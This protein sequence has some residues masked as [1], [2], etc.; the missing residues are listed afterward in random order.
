[1]LL[2]PA[3]D[4]LVLKLSRGRRTGARRRSNSGLACALASVPTFA[5]R[6][7]TPGRG[8]RQCWFKPERH[9]EQQLDQ[10]AFAD[11]WTPVPRVWR[12]RTGLAHERSISDVE[13]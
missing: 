10:P 7:S 13:G 4:A 8:G 12:E 1:M 2:E 6:C 11:Q 3:A 5:W 9:S